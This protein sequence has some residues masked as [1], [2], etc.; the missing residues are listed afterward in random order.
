[1]WIHNI[2]GVIAIPNLRYALAAPQLVFSFPALIDASLL[3]MI[4]WWW[5]VW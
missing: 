2:G 3:Q 4:Q 5:R 1:M